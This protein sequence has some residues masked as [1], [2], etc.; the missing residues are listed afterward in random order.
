M[1]IDWTNTHLSKEI[2]THDSIFS[3]FHYDYDNRTVL[4]RLVRWQEGIT[5]CFRLNNVILFN[6][7]SCDFWHGGDRIYDTCCYSEHPFFQQLAT[8]QRENA[9]NFSGSYLD[10]DTK[11]IVF[12]LQIV[13][14]DEFLAICENVEYSIE[15]GITAV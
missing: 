15:D 6:M 11:Y 2:Y 1:I 14:G 10:T 5:Q 12:A 7:Q 8:V 4:F 9:N 3:G 13:S